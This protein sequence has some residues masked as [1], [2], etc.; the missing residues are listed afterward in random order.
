M[1]R[2]WFEGGS[3]PWVRGGRNGE[4]LKL[5]VSDL[6]SQ[7]K[8]EWLCVAKVFSH[9]KFLIYFG[10]RYLP[11]TRRKTPTLAENNHTSQ[12]R[13]WFHWHHFH[14][15]H[16]SST[17]RCSLFFHFLSATSPHPSPSSTMGCLWSHKHHLASP[18]DDVH[19]KSISTHATNT[20]HKGV[21]SYWDMTTTEVTDGARRRSASTNPALK[22]LDK[23]RTIFGIGRVDSVVG[24]E[25][26]K[27]V[28][29]IMSDWILAKGQPVIMYALPKNVNFCARPVSN[30]RP[31]LET[32][33]STNQIAVTIKT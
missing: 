16:R 31:D 29:I 33:T 7:R 19:E 10:L 5:T 15:N 21:S 3:G 8:P 6:D 14:C 23:V 2:I 28:R 18:H 12:H 26:N 24:E 22:P 13:C 4:K 27:R 17:T 11:G 9:L 32:K 20:L 1:I 25:E 30:T